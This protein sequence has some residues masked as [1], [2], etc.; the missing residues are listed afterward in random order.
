M[1][2]WAVLFEVEWSSLLLCPSAC[3]THAPVTVPHDFVSPGLNVGSRVP[4]QH[5]PGE[6][7]SS[8]VVPIKPGLLAVFARG[9]V[10]QTAW[11]LVFL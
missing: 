7:P 5:H 10:P 9:N 11:V 8:V 6:V 4:R 2:P 3:S 1:S